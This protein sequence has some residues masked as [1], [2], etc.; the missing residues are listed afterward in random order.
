MKYISVTTALKPFNSFGHIDPEVL[1]RAAHRG[2]RVHKACSAYVNGLYVLPFDG[3][4]YF[5]SFKAWYDNYVNWAFFVE[6]KFQ[7]DS[8]RFFGHP[9]LVC[10]LIDNRELVVDFKTPVTESPLWKAQLAAYLHL[11]RKKRGTVQES[12][13]LQL[14]PDGKMARGITYQYHDNDFAAFLSALNAYRYFKAA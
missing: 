3:F 10:R 2:T 6:R 9:D 5:E 12:M 8:Y 13:V 4:E 14:R 1:A 11:V 7:D